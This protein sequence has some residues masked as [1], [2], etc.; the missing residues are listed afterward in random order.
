MDLPSL[1][2][3]FNVVQF[4]G[5]HQVTCHPRYFIFNSDKQK[6][7]TWFKYM[8]ILRKIFPC[9]LKNFA[10]F[11]QNTLSQEKA[12]FLQKCHFETPWFLWFC[13]IFNSFLLFLMNK[14]IILKKWQVSQ[15]FVVQN[16]TSISMAI[17]HSLV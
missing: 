1:S 17:P 6:S 5:V 2:N 7:Q 16:Y 11:Y 9:L 15:K 8:D 12:W 3:N 13:M 4:Q 14:D 10:M